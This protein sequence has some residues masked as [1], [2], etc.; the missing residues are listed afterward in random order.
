MLRLRSAPFAVLLQFDFA[1]DELLVFARPIVD[2]RTLR[3]GKFYE[4]VL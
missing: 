3:A 1:L 2:A 4:L